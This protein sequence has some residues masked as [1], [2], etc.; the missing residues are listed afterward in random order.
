[1]WQVV[2]L[3]PNARVERPRDE[4]GCAPEVHDGVPR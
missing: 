1:M 2:N 4:R 3:L